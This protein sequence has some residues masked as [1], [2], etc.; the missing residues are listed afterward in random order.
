MNCIIESNYSQRNKYFR[1][2][3]L[4]FVNLIR[5][6]DQKSNRGSHK[7]KSEEYICFLKII[8]L[9]IYKCNYKITFSIWYS[10]YVLTYYQS[11]C[12]WD[13]K[14]LI[15]K[16]RNKAA[17]ESWIFSYCCEIEILHNR[18]LCFWVK[19]KFTAAVTLT[20]IAFQLVCLLK[21][22]LLV[23]VI[24]LLKSVFLRSGVR[25]WVFKLFL[26]KS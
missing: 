19:F 16:N 26:T 9:F 20:W 12:M 14:A 6:R 17:M 1:T 22:C 3:R 7:K 23:F 24:S 18:L 15:F 10:I 25:T 11:W 2:I 8:R 5:E 4:T 21:I 13:L